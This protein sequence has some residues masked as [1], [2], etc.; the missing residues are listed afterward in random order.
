MRSRNMAAIKGRNTR[1]ELAVRK[2]LH[3]LGYRFR[4]HRRDLPGTPDIVLPKYKTVIFVHGC[5]WHRHP[6][7][8]F[9]TNPKTNWTFWDNKFH[10]NID[11]DKKNWIG[12][13]TAT[14]RVLV[15]WECQ[16]RDLASLE[17]RLTESLGFK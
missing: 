15:V 5:F 4:L 12:L 8:R 2:M 10:Q 9:T 1:P 7:C 17:T 16:T 11:R 13:T 14:W 6:G 3:R